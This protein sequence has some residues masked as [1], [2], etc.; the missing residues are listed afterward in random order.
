MSPSPAATCTGRACGKVILAGEHAAVYGY[1]AV[2][3]ALDRGA[4]AHVTPLAAQGPSTLRLGELEL[5]Q[6]DG[7][8]LARAFAGVLGRAR[9]VHVEVTT[10]LPPGSGLGSSA[11]IG[12]AIIRALDPGA[13]ENEVLE[14]AMQ[15]ERVFHGNPSGLD[16]F[17]AARGG[18]FSF[19]RGKKAIPI[20]VPERA[21]LCIG[22]SGA[23]ASTKS[24]V[25]GV[26]AM[27]RRA[28]QVANDIFCSIGAVANE[29][30]RRLSAGELFEVGRLMTMNHALLQRLHVST[31]AIDAMCIRAC[32]VGA[33]G[34]KLTGGGGGGCVVALC[35][36]ELERDAVLAEWKRG[37]FEGFATEIGPS[38]ADNDR[39]SGCSPLEAG[40]PIT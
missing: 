28:P 2:A 19:A 38:G 17:I 5:T 14:R 31:P 8:D 27:H 32:A 21:F 23:G 30:T 7:H 22:Q 15:W 34:A 35:A 25:D 39:S 10:T 12:V 11:A 26:A 9:P 6:R 37:F 20:V 4:A 24:M 33:Y 16:A 40:R 29:L 13:S 36:T 18:A 1:R 3:I